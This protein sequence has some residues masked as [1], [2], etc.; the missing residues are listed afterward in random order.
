M[1]QVDDDVLALFRLAG[2]H[3]RV[4]GRGEPRTRGQVAHVAGA[5]HAFGP[6]LMGQDAGLGQTRMVVA[7]V[8]CVR[9][10]DDPVREQ[11]RQ[12][13]AGLALVDEGVEL[14][15]VH[16]AG[17]V[18]AA[19]AP[20]TARHQRAR[21][22]QQRDRIAVLDGPAVVIRHRAGR[23]LRQQHRVVAEHQRMHGCV[24]VGAVLLAGPDEPEDAGK[25]AQA[26]DEG[27]VRFAGLPGLLAHRILGA[28]DQQFEIEGPRQRG[29]TPAPFPDQRFQNIRQAHCP[30]HPVIDTLL[31]DGQR[32]AHGQLHASQATIRMAHAHVGHNAM[33][34]V[35]LAPVRH[36]LDR[37]G[38]A[39]QRGLGQIGPS[40]QAGHGAID[41]HA[42]P[43]G[44]VDVL[45]HQHL[46]QLALATSPVQAER[47]LALVE[48][49][50]HGAVDVDRFH[51]SMHPWKRKRHCRQTA[52]TPLRRRN[53]FE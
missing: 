37:H 34:R 53:R 40:R 16:P 17:L 36:E 7:R 18:V 11:C 51:V 25:A 9:R 50:S 24:A 6:V 23:G 4:A 41:A 43:L 32:I 22:R 19:R 52:A 35:Q 20:H 28:V 8:A 10:V 46:L 31:K 21:R 38:A 12:V 5:V 1:A 13:V 30:E 47:A 44:H 29:A 33:D 15:H 39:H 49:L 2:V 26:P 3:L 42:Q 48:R 27:R 45:R 14:R